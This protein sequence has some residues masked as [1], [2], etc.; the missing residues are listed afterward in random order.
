MKK[1]TLIALWAVFLMLPAAASAYETNTGE[2]VYIAKDRIVE[3]NL[4]S[5][6][7]AITIDGKITGDLICAGQSITING[8]VEGDVICAGQNLSINGSVKGSIRGAGS[9]LMLNGPVGKNVMFFGA[10]YTLGEKGEIGWDNML[11]VATGHLQGKIGRSLHGAAAALTLDNAINGDV[12]LRIDD[13]ENKDPGLKIGDRAQINGSLNY[14]SYREADISSQAKIKGEKKHNLPEA[15]GK[16]KNKGFEQG[17]SFIISL[18]SALLIGIILTNLWPEMTKKISVRMRSEIGASFGWGSVLLIITPIICIFLLFTI[19]GIPLALISGAA[20]LALLYISGIFSGAAL[21]GIITEKYW[22][23]KKDSLGW[24][25]AA[26]IAA[27]WIMMHIPFIGPV[28]GM[29]S[30]L[31]GLGGIFLYGKERSA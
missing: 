6:G 28:F 27:V 20:Y 22:I 8:I 12:R 17:W 5:A 30:L 4:Y 21:G 18:F 15:E 10:N 7:S 9:S 23:A 29:A 25:M 16:G 1:T 13:R 24:S 11:A 19:I 26:G 3:G 14:S 2:S 31:W